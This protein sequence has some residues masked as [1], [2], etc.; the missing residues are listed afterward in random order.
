MRVVHYDNPIYSFEYSNATMKIKEI[1]QWNGDREFF[2]E[3]VL[4][5]NERITLVTTTNRDE[6]IAT[7]KLLDIANEN[8]MQRVA[9]EFEGL[10]DVREFMKDPDRYTVDRLLYE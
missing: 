8:I 3:A 5:S 6:A 7:I 1:D 2:V 9:V 4:P 10:S